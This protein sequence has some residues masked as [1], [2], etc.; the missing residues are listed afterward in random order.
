[1]KKKVIF[2]QKFIRRKL[3]NS[4][5]PHISLQNQ[6]GNNVNLYRSDTFRLVLYFYS[7]TGRPD[8]SLPLNWN[9]IEGASG[10]TIQNCI[11][12]DNYAY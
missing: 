12:R 1:M 3:I 4:L 10:C 6:N 11:F 2:D 5:I 7:L 8:R 9:K